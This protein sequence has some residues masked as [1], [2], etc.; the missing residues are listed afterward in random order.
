MTTN[1]LEI[2]QMAHP[3][4]KA[5]DLPIIK[6]IRFEVTGKTLILSTWD[7]HYRCITRQIKL[8]RLSKKVLL[9]VIAVLSGIRDEGAVARRIT[10]EMEAYL[11]RGL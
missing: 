7:K 8:A 3:E 11:E 2:A 1:L 9:K 6:G 10:P 5:E 4:A